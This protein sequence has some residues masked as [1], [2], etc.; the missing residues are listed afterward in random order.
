MGDDLELNIILI[1]VILVLIGGAIKGFRSG[2]IAEVSSLLSLISALVVVSIFVIGIKEY[3]SD[4]F[5]H[6]IVAIVILLIVV[7]VYK[8]VNFILTSLGIIMKL[9]IASGINRILGFALGGIKGVVF[10]WI[11]LIVIAYVKLGPLNN[12]IIE[13]VNKSK[14]LTVLAQNNILARFM[15]Y[16]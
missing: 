6:V 8:I 5:V 9:P 4:E 1:V 3:M 15:T 10:L 11:F 12:I 13:G 7:T 2:F 14:F 16:L